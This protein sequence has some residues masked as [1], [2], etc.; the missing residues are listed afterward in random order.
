MCA[1]R[2]VLAMVALAL[3]GCA[4]SIAAADAPP[5]RA[6]APRAPSRTS[7]ATLER[8]VFD[9]VN[10][11]RAARRLPALELDARIGKEARR[12]SAAMAAGTRSVGHGGFDDRVAALKRVMWFRRSAEN[13]AFN[14]GYRDAAAQAVRGWLASR[15]H[16][17]NIEGRYVATGIGVARSPD[18]GLS[19]TQIFVG[20]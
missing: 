7:V 15:G 1:R 5:G 4:G 8:Q 14:Q 2:V 3:A 9:L 18:G 10:R 13:V 6:G 17:E 16:R 12:H 19:F 11:H 20:R